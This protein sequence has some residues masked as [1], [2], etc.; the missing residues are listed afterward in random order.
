IALAQD[1]PAAPRAGTTVDRARGKIKGPAKSSRSR[2]VDSSMLRS[3]A[4]IAAPL[5]LRQRQVTPR[6]E[7]DSDA[8]T[9]REALGVGTQHIGHHPETLVEVH[10]RD[11]IRHVAPEGRRGGTV[12]DGDGVNAPLADCTRPQPGQS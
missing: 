9:D 5:E 4:R 10:E 12:D 1:A 11:G 8:V 2:P 3:R 7:D 6:F